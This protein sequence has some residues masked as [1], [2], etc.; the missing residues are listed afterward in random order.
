MGTML[1]KVTRPVRK[2]GTGSAL[3]RIAAD[4]RADQVPPHRGR[5]PGG[6]A[7]T[8]ELVQGGAQG[9]E[10]GL[11]VLVRIEE[12]GQQ[13]VD[14][15]DPVRQSSRADQIGP[16]APKGVDEVLETTQGERLRALQVRIGQDPAIE[17]IGRRQGQPQEEATQPK[18][19]GVG[20]LA[21]Q[22]QAGAHG[23]VETPAH[24]G[25]GHP[26]ADTF[27]GLRRRYR[28][29]GP[30]PAP[31]AS[32]GPPPPPAGSPVARA[33]RPPRPAGAAPR[34]GAGRRWTRGCAG[35]A[36]RHRRWPRCAGRRRRCPGPC[37]GP[38]GA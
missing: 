35:R 25:L 4:L 22:V 19:P 17:G 38:D 37:R 21:R 9:L 14:G 5:Q 8:G 1:Q 28:S 11:V 29:A 32:P 6:G 10:Q 2:R 18:G 30:G 20:V 7:I 24:P 12:V 13:P 27:Q 23:P 15:T 36:V 3:S 33:G 26:G 31:P 34:P 16:P